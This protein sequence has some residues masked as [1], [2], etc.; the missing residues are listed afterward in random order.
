M[1]IVF[2]YAMTQHTVR[3]APEENWSRQPGILAADAST[4]N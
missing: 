2:E 4:G 3:E 1:N